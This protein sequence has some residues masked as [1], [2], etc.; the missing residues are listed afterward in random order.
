M[1]SN[2][3]YCGK[4][5]R[6][7]TLGLNMETNSLAVVKGFLSKDFAMTSMACIASKNTEALYQLGLDAKA[8]RCLAK[9][10]SKDVRLAEHAFKAALT[11]QTYVDPNILSQ[12][13]IGN[14]RQKSEE[15]F[16]FHLL[17]AGAGFEMLRHFLKSYT[18]RNHTE[19]RQ[20]FGI[21]DAVI[22]KGKTVVP[23]IE[24]DNFFS[25]FEKN[26]KEINIKDILDF[27]VANNY[28]MSSIWRELKIFIKNEA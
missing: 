10:G 17:S 11:V 25:E 28:S 13:L 12:V 23:E 5:R 20:K 19:L 2:Y 4:Y 18:N 24:A 21:D 3:S 16:I 22:K 14:S 26:G 8:I 1:L 27:S 6:S 7:D 15:D 9:I